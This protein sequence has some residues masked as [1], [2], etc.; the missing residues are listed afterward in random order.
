MRGY[1]MSWAAFNV[2]EILSLG[3]FAAKRIGYQAASLCFSETTEVV[4]LSTNL[5]RKVLKCIFMLNFDY[6]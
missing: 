4:M 6:S 5:L 2:I 1:E 3:R